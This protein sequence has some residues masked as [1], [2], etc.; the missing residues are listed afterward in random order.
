M[1]IWKRLT[2]DVYIGFD[3]AKKSCMGGRE[4]HKE[5]GRTYV[6]ILYQEVSHSDPGTETLKIWLDYRDQRGEK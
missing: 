2:W 4:R 5:Q 1:S 6:E 3:S